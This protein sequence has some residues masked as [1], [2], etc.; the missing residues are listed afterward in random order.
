[1][2]PFRGKHF[3]PYLLTSSLSFPHESLLHSCETHIKVS[4]LWSCLYQA[5]NSQR[6]DLP[7]YPFIPPQYK[8]R[9]LF[10]T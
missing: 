10:Y 6:D 2:S 9:L 3:I 7:S 1:M 8:C 4:S 5:V